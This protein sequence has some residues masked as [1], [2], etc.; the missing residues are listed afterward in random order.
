MLSILLKMLIYKEQ[1]HWDILIPVKQNTNT[2]PQGL[3]HENA[4]IFT[5]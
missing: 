2:K 4:Q 5:K 1:S 3:L